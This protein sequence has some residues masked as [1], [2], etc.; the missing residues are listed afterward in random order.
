MDFSSYPFDEQICD[1][2]FGSTIYQSHQM[3]F[4][5]EYWTLEE[6]VKH[7]VYNIEVS[8]YR[9]FNAPLH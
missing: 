3:Q 5:S 1:V 8:Q 7:H 2:I 9:K 6:V 4:W